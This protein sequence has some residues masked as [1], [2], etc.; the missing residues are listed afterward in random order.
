MT[1]NLYI[2]EYYYIYIVIVA[3]TSPAALVGFIKALLFAGSLGRSLGSLSEFVPKI[4]ALK[5]K[6]GAG[7]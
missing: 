6:A 3:F 1:I 2:Y 5:K 4:Q 7:S